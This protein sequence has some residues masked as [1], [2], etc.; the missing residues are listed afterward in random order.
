MNNQKR[1][2]SVLAKD[3]LSYIAIK[4]ALGRDFASAVSV[5]FSLDRFLFELRKPPA[6]LGSQT[7]QQWSKT[8]ESLSSNTRLARMLAI[9]N[10]C[11]YRRRMEPDCFIPDRSQFPKACPLLR[12][13]IFSEGEVARLLGIPAKV[14][15]HSEGKV[16]SIPG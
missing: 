10:F 9:R 3:I 4:Q 6:D 13:Y 8:L 14:N 5:L 1:F 15:A 7:F 16:N 2:R 12:P 11:I